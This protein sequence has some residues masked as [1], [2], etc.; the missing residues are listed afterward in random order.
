MIK[1]FK[2]NTVKSIQVSIC[3]CLSHSHRWF[4]C[5][6]HGHYWRCKNRRKCEDK[7]NYINNQMNLAL[8]ETLK[9]NFL[10][11]T[12][13]DVFW[14]GKKF[15]VYDIWPGPCIRGEYGH[16][17]RRQVCQMDVE[18]LW[19]KNNCQNWLSPKVPEHSSEPFYPPLWKN[20][21]K[22][23]FVLWTMSGMVKYRSAL[24][25]FLKLTAPVFYHVW[26]TPWIIIWIIS[27]N[28]QKRKKNKN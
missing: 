6:L 16:G 12:R 10:Y 4:F 21:I 13:W 9:P 5:L 18:L 20:N 7:N 19:R 14:W 17:K 28:L 24:W 22:Y 3:F 1:T 8:T 15:E 27:C 11:L 23:K 25:S 26:H 2:K